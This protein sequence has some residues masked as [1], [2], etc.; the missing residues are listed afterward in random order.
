MNIQMIKEDMEMD[1]PGCMD[2]Y[3]Q[4][5][6]DRKLRFRLVPKTS[7][8]LWR[9]NFYTKMERFAKG[10][11]DEWLDEKD[12][13]YISHNV[14][15]ILNSV[16]PDLRDMYTNYYNDTKNYH[17]SDELRVHLVIGEI[18][19]LLNDVEATYEEIR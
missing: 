7:A 4:I 12:F 16:I 3:G 6:L 19:R 2:A 5:I 11:E 13:K 10:L 17:N 15:I 9:H 18:L 8:M 14:K 1:F